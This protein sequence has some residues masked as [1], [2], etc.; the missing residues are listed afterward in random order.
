VALGSADGKMAYGAF[1]DSAE[2][3]AVDLE[4]L[5]VTYLPATSNGTGTFTVGLSNNVCH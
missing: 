4:E 1:S 2:V 3:A 5:V